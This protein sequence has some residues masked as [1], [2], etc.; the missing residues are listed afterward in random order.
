M[1]NNVIKEIILI[2]MGPASLLETWSGVPYFLLRELKNRGIIVREID[3][4]PHRYIKWLY[5]RIIM[6]FISLF[7]NKGELS[8]YRSLFFRIYQYVVL[9]NKFRRYES[10]DVILGITSFNI[11]VPKTTKPIVMLSDWPFSY[12]LMRKNIKVGWYQTKCIKYEDSCMRK[13]DLL[14]SL[15]PTCAKYINERLEEH[16]AKSLG[17]NVVNNLQSPPKE[18]IIEK[19]QK[20]RIVF[21]GRLHYI[22]G[23]ISLLDA[24]NELFEINPNIELD[25][26]GLQSKDFPAIIINKLK[27]KVRFWGYLDKG[28][29]EQCDIYYNIIKKASLYVNTTPGWVGYTSMI[30]AMYFY[31]PVIVYPCTEFV[32]EFGEEIEFGKYLKDSKYLAQTI[33]EVWSQRDYQKMAQKSHDRVSNYTW[34]HFVDELLSDVVSLKKE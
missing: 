16:K 3:L 7:V 8:I 19:S 2:S 10:A 23:A 4:E 1:S 29:K 14:I 28:N 32:D 30:E 17:V 33:L 20:C 18:S 5:N 11:S 34:T 6:P 12:D 15:F 24:Y 9:T 25:I 26:I 13:A 22:S 31:T 21:I 27:G